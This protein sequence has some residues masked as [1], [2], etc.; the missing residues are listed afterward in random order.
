MNK[1][2][3]WNNVE[4]CYLDEGWEDGLGSYKLHYYINPEP[5]NEY[6]VF[7]VKSLCGKFYNHSPFFNKGKLANEVEDYEGECCKIC[8][9]LLRNRLE[10]K[11]L[12]EYFK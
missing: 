10:H 9:R 2:K 8:I 5:D 1:I 6:G 11:P 4:G 3:W 7:N 12:K